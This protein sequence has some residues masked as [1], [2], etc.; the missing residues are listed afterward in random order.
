MSYL[1]KDTTK[2]EVV[3]KRCVHKETL[4]QIKALWMHLRVC[5]IRLSLS[6]AEMREPP[7]P[8]VKIVLEFDIGLSQHMYKG[9]LCTFISCSFFDFQGFD[10]F[11]RNT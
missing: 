7:I 6:I 4:I 11:L 9:V 8:L 10:Y 2:E 5:Q 3:L 1:I